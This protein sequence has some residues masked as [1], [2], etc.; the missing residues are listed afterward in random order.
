MSSGGAAP[1]SDLTK[2]TEMMSSRA[3]SKGDPGPGRLGG[4]TIVALQT[5]IIG[6]GRA[7]LANKELLSPLQE[8]ERILAAAAEQSS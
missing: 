2:L 5:V 1:A 6:A 3:R 8:A 4:A 7:L